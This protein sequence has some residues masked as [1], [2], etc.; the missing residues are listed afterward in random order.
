MIS[1]DNINFGNMFIVG[2]EGTELNQTLAKKLKDLDP[3]GVI[4]FDCNIQSREQVKKLIQDLK[5]LLGTNLIVSVDQE[6]GK[7]QRLRKISP[8]LPSLI[9]IGKLCIE[10]ENRI[11]IRQHTELLAADL[12]DLG[13]NFVFAP[14]L[15][16]N[17][18][19]T[20][21]VIG[22]RSLGNDCKEVLPLIEPII[23]VFRSFG[24]GCCAKH[25]PGHG[26]TNKDSHIDLP[27]IHIDEMNYMGHLSPFLQAIEENIPA[28]MT[29]HILVDIEDISE[30]ST[31]CSTHPVSLS[32]DFIMDDL[33]SNFGFQG[34]V[35]SDE[36]T[37]KALSEYGDYQELALEMIYAGNN[38]IIW[39]TNLDD[40]IKVADY[41][42]KLKGNNF[43]LKARYFDA[44]SKI[45][46]FYQFYLPTNVKAPQPNLAELESEMQ[47]AAID[48]IEF[49]TPQETL[50]E[51]F[52]SHEQELEQK[53]TAIV[54]LS[55]PK[56]EETEFRE[57]FG[58]DI[59]QVHSSKDFDESF[60]SRYE[61]ILLINFQTHF[62][63]EGR[64]LIKKFLKIDSNVVYICTDQTDEEADLNLLGAAKI[65]YQAL[66]QVLFS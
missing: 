4:F 41:L 46:D 30:G 16:L 57:V 38:L 19:I 55:H 12:K 58:L 54:L 27:H 66:K 7:V 8:N 17:T 2:F 52:T 43:N 37:M 59:Y 65:H 34:L 62:T 23:E 21:P 40:A 28:I 1:T 26:P 18:D 31:L 10:R 44:I 33:R 3:A 42:N 56:L 6:G 64:R 39:N 11:L 35:I 53:N 49:N 24:I 15:D 32:R 61:N 45:L 50:Q 47:Q 22:T 9:S 51:Y 13:F 36:I 25:F 5:D 14:C 29:A 20:N 63:E 48:A 60:F